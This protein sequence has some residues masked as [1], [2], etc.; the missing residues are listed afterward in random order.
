MLC[1]VL[2]LASCVTWPQVLCSPNENIGRR[3]LCPSSILTL[4]CCDR[5]GV[6]LSGSLTVMLQIGVCRTCLRQF[7]SG[8]WDVMMMLV[9]LDGL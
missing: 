3:L 5:C 8:L 4:S 6:I 1:V 9:D 7:V 2:V